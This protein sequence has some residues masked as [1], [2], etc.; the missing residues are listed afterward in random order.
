MCEA[1]AKIK[2]KLFSI[3]DKVMGREK[4]VVVVKVKRP[5]NKDPICQRS[6]DPYVDNLLIR[7]HKERTEWIKKTFG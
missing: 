7:D 2:E 4:K 1:D 6:T 3:A 5:K